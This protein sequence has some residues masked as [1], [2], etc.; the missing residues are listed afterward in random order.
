MSGSLCVT[1]ALGET[2]ALGGTADSGGTVALGRHAVLG[3][4]SDPNCDSDSVSVLAVL[5]SSFMP[6]DGDND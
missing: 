2:D 5:D 3:A 6:S 4:S 1:A